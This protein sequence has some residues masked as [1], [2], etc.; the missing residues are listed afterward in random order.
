MNCR[1]CHAQAIWP[2][3]FLH[4][5]FSLLGCGKL[6]RILRPIL[7]HPCLRHRYEE[8]FDGVLLAH[9]TKLV[10]EDNKDEDNKDNKGEV[11]GKKKVKKV[12]ILRPK[13]LRAKI[14][15]GLVPYFGVRVHSSLLVFSPKPDMILGKL[16]YFL[17]HH[18]K[19]KAY[20]R[21]C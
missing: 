12:K 5:S 1:A 13:I 8:R 10:D 3:A 19:N 9:N 7:D 2:C 18:R 4:F 6:F 17:A 21:F 20:Q 11:E 14:L 16:L 15:N